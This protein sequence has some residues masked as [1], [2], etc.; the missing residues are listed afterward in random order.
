MPRAAAT[1]RVA[2]AAAMLL[3]GAFPVAAQDRCGVE[4]WPVKVL[5]DRDTALVDLAPVP[6]T[7]AAL[8]GLPRPEGPFANDRRRDLERRTFRVRAILRHR[9]FSDDDSD[10]RLILA[11][12]AAPATTIIAEMPHP[13][14][15][16]GSAHA[17]AYAEARR[18]AIT[19]PIG[20][21]IEVEGVAFWDRPHGQNWMA[22]NAIELH[23]VLRVTPLADLGMTT[24]PAPPRAPPTPADT[25]TIRVWL[26][27]SS[28]VYH[29]PGTEYYGRTARGEILTEAE[30]RGRGGRPAG[31]RP[32]QRS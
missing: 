9:D 15:A 12:P 28:Q 8:A 11:D 25:S 7:V 29:C 17:A 30:A 27:L 14:C 31:G 16:L 10:L 18:V 2:V 20:A 3:A 22:P 4:R 26:N 23:P 5:A 24:G 19:L 1:G 13:Q 6:T 32:C 21:E